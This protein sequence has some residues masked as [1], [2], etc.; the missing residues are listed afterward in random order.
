MAKK[1]ELEDTLDFQLKAV[2]LPFVREHR[3]HPTR[4]WRFDFAN[5]ERKLAIEVQG[6]LWLKK[7]GHTSGKGVTRDIEKY[8]EALRLGWMI[9]YATAT[10]IK[11]GEALS[12]VKEMW[13][14]RDEQN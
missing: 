1:S 13:K 8:N 10:T 11:S 4:R 9:L 14:Q 12:L 6:G 7:G 5:K 3:F 2:S